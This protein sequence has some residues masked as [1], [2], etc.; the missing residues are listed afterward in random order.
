MVEEATF[1]VM[2]L[3]VVQAGC[4]RIL[5]QEA[6]TNHQFDDGN[7]NQ[8]LSVTKYGPLRAGTSSFLF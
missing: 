3:F 2:S 5:Q 4:N 7:D 6:R 1:V 8:K